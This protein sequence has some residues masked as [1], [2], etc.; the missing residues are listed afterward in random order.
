MEQ[1]DTNEDMDPEEMTIKVQHE[2]TY[3]KSRCADNNP[4]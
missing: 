2:E 3:L 4:V 1:G